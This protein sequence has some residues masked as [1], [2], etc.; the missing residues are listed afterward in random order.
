MIKIEKISNNISTKGIYM[1]IY[2]VDNIDNWNEFTQWLYSLEHKEMTLMMPGNI[3]HFYSAEERIHF[4]FGF[5]KA[6]EVI[7]DT[8]LK[9]YH[10]DV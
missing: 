7:D 2:M 10:G 6:W 4:V 5:M 8:Y 9:K 1:P 3:Y